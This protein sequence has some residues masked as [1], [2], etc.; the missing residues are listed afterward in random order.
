MLQKPEPSGRLLK[1][2]IEL[3]QFDLNFHH[4]IEINGQGLADFI[5]EFTYASTIEIIGMTNDVE[6]AKVV[7]ARDKE[8]SAPIQEDTP[9]D[10]LYGW[11]L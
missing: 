8:E 7:E 11:C 9:V 10:P 3:G 2:A 5:E 1:W 6:A 4:R